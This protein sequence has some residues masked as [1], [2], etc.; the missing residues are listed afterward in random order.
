MCS[1]KA[2]D[3]TFLVVGCLQHGV[4]ICDECSTGSSLLVELKA[5]S[6]AQ[7]RDDAN[8][9]EAFRHSATV[10]TG[11]FPPAALVELYHEP[12]AIAA[13]LRR[14]HLVIVDLCHPRKTATRTEKQFYQQLTRLRDDRGVSVTPIPLCNRE[15]WRMEMGLG[16]LGTFGLPQPVRLASAIMTSV[17]IV[18]SSG[19]AKRL[20]P[21]THGT[22]CE[23]HI[24]K[25][26]N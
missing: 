25:S 2:W 13:R 18:L 1:A 15:E 5:R 10:K 4:G 19:I 22:P 3:A 12:E 17:K 23:T 14:L 9:L 16:A 21:L 26:Q 20:R 7:S 24:Q 8:F 11:E 6:P